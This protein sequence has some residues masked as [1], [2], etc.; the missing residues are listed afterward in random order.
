MP[1]ANPFEHA[2][3]WYW[4]DETGEVSR[5]FKT[6]RAALRDLLNYLDWLDNGPNLWQRIWW[7][8]KEFFRDTR[9]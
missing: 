5:A 6:Q 1:K 8:L 3:H 7:P 4:L 9:G 2:G